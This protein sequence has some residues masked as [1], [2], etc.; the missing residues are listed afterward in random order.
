[1][2]VFWAA[3]DFCFSRNVSRKDWPAHWVFQAHGRGG[4]AR[5]GTSLAPPEPVKAAVAGNFI[6]DDNL[7]TLNRPRL[8]DGQPIGWSERNRRFEDKVRTR[9]RPRK[10]DPICG[11][12]NAQRIRDAPNSAICR[13]L[14]TRAVEISN[15]EKFVAGGRQCRNRLITLPAYATTQR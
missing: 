9:G 7:P 3:T 5:H 13:R 15:H 1:M 4:G 8:G 12:V 11:E 14:A 10:R 2:A 6:G